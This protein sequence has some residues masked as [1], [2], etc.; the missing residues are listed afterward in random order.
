VS[1]I[2]LLKDKT[3]DNSKNILKIHLYM[4]KKIGLYFVQGFFKLTNIMTPKQRNLPFYDDVS[5][6]DMKHYRYHDFALSLITCRHFENSVKN[7]CILVHVDIQ[8]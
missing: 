4:L 8:K 1:N 6:S 5:F 3:V 2:L 7:D